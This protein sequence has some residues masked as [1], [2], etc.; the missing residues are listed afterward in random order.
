MLDP[1]LLCLDPGAMTDFRAATLADLPAAAALSARIGWNQTPADWRLFLEHGA[2]RALADDDA[3]CLAA[4]AAVLPYGR[5]LAWISMVLVRPDRRREGL[6]TT[7]MRWAIERLNGTACIALDATP[8][9][10]PVYRRL[11]FVDVFGFTRWALPAGLRSLPTATRPIAP[12]DWPALLAL[13]ATAFGAPRGALLRRFAARQPAAALTTPDRRGF[14]LAREGR[15]APQIG[16][17]VAPDAQTALALVAAA[18][19]ALAMPALIDLNDAA[20]DL[21]TLL[22]ATAQRSF[23]RMT[24]GAPPP[25]DPSQNFVLAGPEFG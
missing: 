3:N 14:V 10:Q 25:G 18:Q 9:G 4:T 8:A 2:V 15:G 21:A 20:R 23:T 13:D 5:D 7:L 11:G 1:S 22:G 12:A 19:Q 24:L 17:V 6:A 16:P